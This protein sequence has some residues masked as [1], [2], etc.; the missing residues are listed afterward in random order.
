MF[1]S[2]NQR[3]NPIYV[4]TVT[5]RISPVDIQGKRVTAL[6]AGLTRRFPS[7]LESRFPSGGLFFAR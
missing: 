2:Y 5:G 4:D 7:D 3:S 6:N 1:L